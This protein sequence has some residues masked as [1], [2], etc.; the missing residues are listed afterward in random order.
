SRS[1]ALEFAQGCGRAACHRRPYRCAHVC[2]IGLALR[3]AG[4][5]TGPGLDMGRAGPPGWFA[6][7]TCAI[8]RFVSDD[9][10]L[11]ACA[12]FNSRVAMVCLPQIYPAKKQ[13]RVETCATLRYFAIELLIGYQKGTSSSNTGSAATGSAGRL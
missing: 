13:F 12:I 3:G 8:I 5:D 11:P 10:V 7:L 1:A 9:V 4:I 2:A 6:A